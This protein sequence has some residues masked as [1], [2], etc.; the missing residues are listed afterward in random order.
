MG[1]PAYREEG[2][3]PNLLIPIIEAILDGRTIQA[4]YHTLTDNEITVRQ[5]DPLLSRTA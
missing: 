2:K 3:D 1:I 5:I 4:Q